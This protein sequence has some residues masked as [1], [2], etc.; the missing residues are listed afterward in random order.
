MRRST[1]LLQIAFI[2][3][4]CPYMQ[5]INPCNFNSSFLDS[6]DFYLVTPLLEKHGGPPGGVAC[7]REVWNTL[8][9]RLAFTPFLLF[10]PHFLTE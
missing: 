5:Q 7:I 4:V 10:P 9:T 6:E 8:Y 1:Y 3:T 2:T